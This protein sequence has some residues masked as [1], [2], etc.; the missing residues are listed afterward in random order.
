MLI[1]PDLANF[2]MCPLVFATGLRNRSFAN[3]PRVRASGRWHT[4]PFHYQVVPCVPFEPKFCSPLPYLNPGFFLSKFLQP[5]VG[6]FINIFLLVRSRQSFF[7]GSHYQIEIWFAGHKNIKNKEHAVSPE[8]SHVF[9]SHFQFAQRPARK[10]PCAT[11]FED[12][13]GLATNFSGRV[14]ATVEPGFIT[15]L[16]NWECD[17]S[18]VGFFPSSWG[19]PNSWMVRGNPIYKWMITYDVPP[20]LETMCKIN[21]RP[22]QG[23]WAY[24]KFSRKDVPDLV[25]LGG[26]MLVEKSYM[27]HLSWNHPFIDGM[28]TLMWMGNENGGEMAIWL[29]VNLKVLSPE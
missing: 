21:A 17:G 20:F 28:K 10:W 6:Q 2:V 27:K 1:C 14:A 18:H 25:G 8:F 9:S 16:K 23:P 15:G 12:D 3:H 4:G 22:V 29:C 19:Y 24:P 7:L 13:V 11:I 5:S 26:W